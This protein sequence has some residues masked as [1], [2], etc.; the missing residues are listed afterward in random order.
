MEKVM[1]KKMIGK[2]EMTV[3]YNGEVIGTTC[4]DIVTNGKEEIL[5]IDF[6]INNFPGIIIPIY[7]VEIHDINHKETDIIIEGRE[8]HYL[9]NKK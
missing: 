5:N 4:F 8:V 9:E 3:E 6:N 2:S 7:G 1:E